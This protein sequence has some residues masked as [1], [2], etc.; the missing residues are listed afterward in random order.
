[1]PIV[2]AALLVILLVVLASVLLAPIALVQRYRA[3]TARRPVRGWLAT[4]NLVGISLSIV[5]FLFGAAMTNIWVPQAFAHACGGLAMGAALGVVGLWLTR[6]DVA[7]GKLHYTP[8]RWL[9][10]A[11]SLAV[12]GRLLYGLWRSWDAFRSLGGNATWAA[13]AGVAGSLAAGAIILG[14]Y[15]VFWLG[16]RRRAR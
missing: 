12:A 3:G 8:N 7:A 16:V 15:F 5:L 13:A 1:V 9:V 14:Y 11:I 10:L 2:V 4:I 6:W